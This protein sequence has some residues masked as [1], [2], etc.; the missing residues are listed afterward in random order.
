NCTSGIDAM[1]NGRP[2]IRSYIDAVRKDA[3][4][5]IRRMNNATILSKSVDEWIDHLVEQFANPEIP[6]IYPDRISRSSEHGLIP[7][8]PV[9][10]PA[11]SDGA[12]KIQGLIH[13]F[14][15]PFTGNRNFFFYQPAG[16]HGDFP[17][18]DVRADELVIAIGGSWYKP[19][20]IEAE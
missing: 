18:A 12:P 20:E 5:W 16:W 6:T 9:P 7:A 15:V 3:V 1:S 8:H 2:E 13:Q 10:N 4:D 17:G 14:H 11:H 19:Q